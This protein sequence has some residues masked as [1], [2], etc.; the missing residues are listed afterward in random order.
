MTTSLRRPFAKAKDVVVTVIVIGIIAAYPVGFVALGMAIMGLP[1]LLGLSSN[2][3]RA[4]A[5]VLL[6]LRFIRFVADVLWNNFADEKF[7]NAGEALGRAIRKLLP[8]VLPS[9]Q[10]SSSASR[11]GSAPPRLSRH[12]TALAT[13]V[14]PA[15][16]RG[17]F[18]EEWNAELFV[19]SRLQ[20]ALFVIGIWRK[21]PALAWG[22]RIHSRRQRIR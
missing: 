6:V 1:S 20:R 7:L 8:S 3:T 9:W 10:T 4:I 2:T 21:L 18:A 11:E 22:L 16:D 19:H 15:A 14:L 17:Q 5:A 13:I 12:L